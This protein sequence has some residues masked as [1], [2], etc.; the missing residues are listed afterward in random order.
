[1]RPN[2]KSYDIEA[3]WDDPS[4]KIEDK[5]GCPRADSSLR[6]KLGVQY[7]GQPRP[8]VGSGLMLD[9]SASGMNCRTKHRV[10]PGQ[11]ILVSIP[12]KELPESMSLP[13]R[14]SGNA[15]ITRVTKEDGTISQVAMKFGEE[16]AND[17]NFVLFMDQIHLQS[18]T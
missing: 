6:V 8:L 13:K 12:T 10:K 5:R 7:A 11:R 4:E 1:M 3:E 16:I 15:E 14:F 18:N 2:R 17:M 9:I